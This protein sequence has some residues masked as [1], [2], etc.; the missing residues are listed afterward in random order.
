MK[1]NMDLALLR[2]FEPVIRFTRGEHFF[3]M[4]V[5]P[6]VES[7]SLWM[8]EP[9]RRARCI[10]PEGQL[11]LDRL[12]E[13]LIDGFGTVFFLK[14]IE[15]LNIPELAS[16]ALKEGLK[17][18]EPHEIFRAGP[19]RLARVG[20]A[21]RL[22]DALFTL[23]LLARGRV[24]GDT[25]AAAYR[26]Y[27]RIMRSEEKYCYY[28]R[29]VR[30]QGWIALQYWFFYP[31]NDWRSGFFGANDHEADWE[32]VYVY[33]ANAQGGD[34]QPEWVAYASHDFSGDDLRRRWDDPEVEKV[35]EHPV[36]YCGAGS[37]A[38]YFS[39]GEY[40][41]EIEI[42]FL[43]PLVQIIDRFQGF[44]RT[45]LRHDEHYGEEMPDKPGFNLFRVP[46]VDYARGDG[47][48]IGP[49]GDKEWDEPIL[50]SPSPIWASQ[51]RGLW[52]V[53]VR[54]PFAGENAPAGPLYNRD[55]TVRRS[56]F[57]PLG[58]SGIEKVPPSQDALKLVLD[59]CA[60]IDRDRA[61]LASE[62]EEK[63]Q[64]LTILGVEKVAM[65]GHPHLARIHASH[66]EEIDTL[67]EQVKS[68]RASYASEGVI[69]EALKMH[70]EKLRAGDR[71]DP[72]AH[73]HRAHHPA[74]EVGLR[75]S[76]I[77]ETWAAV[78]VGLVVL[79]FVGMLFFAREYLFVGLAVLLSL[80][81][82]IEA[83]FRRQL[84]RLISNLT[85]ALA[86][87]SAAILLIE[88][89]WTIIVLGVILAGGYIIWENIK[90]LRTR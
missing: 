78:S 18:K 42:S 12:G 84:I 69:L 40:L 2:R 22:L 77:A 68:L 14:F 24:P 86:A 83:A 85:I 25:A 62:I 37:H 43:S 87:F 11:T 32:M 64:R 60:Q 31:F 34:V 13:P 71:G 17:K 10:I 9:R 80:L 72:R 33:L 19:G 44:W 54:D 16:Y 75:L 79:S 76:R 45:L 26:A 30:Q 70:A 67:A 49:G 81:V 5:K 58:W 28:G 29:V 38:S 23:A 56:W 20:Y 50:L 73:I 6:Y 90:E 63:S 47:I 88:F 53:Y 21:S 74:S 48:S 41:T 39:P 27:H 3:P 36:I 7:S 15:P 1:S 55:G 57:D 51:Y 8:Q 35:G 46:F 89:F 65:I 61:N 4:D 59:R 52:G 82:F 66:Q